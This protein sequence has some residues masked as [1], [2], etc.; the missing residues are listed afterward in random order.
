MQYVYLD[1]LIN[2]YS[3][4]DLVGFIFMT[5]INEVPVTTPTTHLTQV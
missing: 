2:L 5:V 4:P 1:K 3:N